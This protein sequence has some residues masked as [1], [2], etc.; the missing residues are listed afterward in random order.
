MAKFHTASGA[1]PAS[2][3]DVIS[4][5]WDTSSVAEPEEP[6]ISW[7]EKRMSEL[8]GSQCTSAGHETDL[9]AAEAAAAEAAIADVAA[10]DALAEAARKAAKFKP[11]AN[12]SDPAVRRSKHPPKDNWSNSTPARNKIAAAAE[13]L[14]EASR[15]RSSATKDDDP[16]TPSKKMKESKADGI[17]TTK[18][19]PSKATAVEVI[20]YEVCGIPGCTRRG[21]PFIKGLCT[22]HC[23]RGSDGK[24]SDDIQR[25]LEATRVDHLGRRLCCIPGCPKAAIKRGKRCNG[26]YNRK[27]RRSTNERKADEAPPMLCT[28]EGCTRFGAPL[29]DGMCWSHFISNGKGGRLDLTQDC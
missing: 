23:P 21:F 29:S 20:P 6:P 19:D 11:S 12:E 16:S 9:A 10:A 25:K 26:H 13:A 24:F 1:T 22:K 7:Y 17:A 27:P 4:T 5:C 2:P 8:W 18:D 28:A 14:A 3:A 15:K